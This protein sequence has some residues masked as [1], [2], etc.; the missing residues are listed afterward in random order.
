[1][2]EIIKFQAWLRAL[3][4][5][6]IM[7]ESKLWAQ[8]LKVEAQFFWAFEQLVHLWPNFTDLICSVHQYPSRQKV[9]SIWAYMCIILRVHSNH[10]LCLFIPNLLTLHVQYTKILAVKKWLPFEL[11]CA[12]YSEYIVTIHC[13]R[14]YPMLLVVSIWAYMCIILRVHSNSSLCPSVPI[15]GTDGHRGFP[16][17]APL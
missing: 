7:D 11:I 4:L 13:V 9:A 12:V 15:L 6:L 14:P 3:G 8:S 10:S 5:N 1:M 16:G 17:N 2:L